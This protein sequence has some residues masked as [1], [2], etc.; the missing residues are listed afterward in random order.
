M[1]KNP[2]KT[3]R[4]NAFHIPQT[5]KMGRAMKNP[6][7]IG[8]SIPDMTKGFDANGR[9]TALMKV[10]VGRKAPVFNILSIKFGILNFSL[11]SCNIWAS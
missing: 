8:I 6:I 3:E 11:H 5:I 10:S 9:L 7:K 4:E 2:R 1:T